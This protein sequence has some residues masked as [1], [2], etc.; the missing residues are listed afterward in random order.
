MRLKIEQ[1]EEAGVPLSPLIDCVFLLLI[2]FLV[3]SM[4]KK[5]EKQ[6]PLVLPEITSSLSVESKQ[7]ASIISLDREGRVYEVLG[8]NA[9]TGEVT[10]Q[11]ISDLA[12][13]LKRFRQTHGTDVPLEIAAP[14]EVSV[15]RVIEVFD[16][17]QLEDLVQT[18][19]RLGGMPSIATTSTERSR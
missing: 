14:A 18:R 19:V 2:F 17:C 11:P 6:I 15:E 3:T 9:Y 5:W 12:G 7:N 10:Y 4:M 8:H 13:Y 1:K 16:M